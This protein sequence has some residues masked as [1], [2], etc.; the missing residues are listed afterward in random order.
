MQMLLN[1][2]IHSQFHLFA[3]NIIFIALNPPNI[4]SIDPTVD[5]TDH[6]VGW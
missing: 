3:L 4:F 5:N 1:I 2:Y 6:N